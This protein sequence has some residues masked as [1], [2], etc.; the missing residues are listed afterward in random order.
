MVHED[1]VKKQTGSGF[2]FDKSKGMV[3]LH[4]SL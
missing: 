3:A 4:F 2:A 1:C